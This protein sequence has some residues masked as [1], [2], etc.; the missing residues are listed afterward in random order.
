MQ[1]TFK[2]AVAVMLTFLL[3]FALVITA[4]PKAYAAT[5]SEIDALK[6]Q[7]DEL[8]SQQNDVQSTINSLK[9]KQASYLFLYNLFCTFRQKL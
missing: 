8:K 7:R 9:N 6:S 3:V 1:K 4:V 5:Q 2:P